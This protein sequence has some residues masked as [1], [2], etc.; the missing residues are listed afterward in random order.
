LN[1]HVHALV[2]D[3]VLGRN[4]AGVVSLF[5]TRRLAYLDVEE[6]LATVEPRIKRLIDRRGLA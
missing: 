6:V 3:G 4:S 2:L 1:L 5:P